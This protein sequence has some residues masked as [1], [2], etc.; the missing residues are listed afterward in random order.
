[1][2]ISKE[3]GSCCLRMLQVAIA[4]LF[5]KWIF[6]KGIDV[7]LKIEIDTLFLKWFHLYNINKLKIKKSKNTK[8]PKEN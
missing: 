8:N 2:A 5:T 6:A 7:I 4:S 1:M 3:N